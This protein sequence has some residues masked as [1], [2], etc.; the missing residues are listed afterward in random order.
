M[1]L[2]D[3]HIDP[4]VNRIRPIVLTGKRIPLP[5]TTAPVIS[6]QMAAFLNKLVFR[7]A[8]PNITYPA[9]RIIPDIS[10]PVTTA[11]LPDTNAP[12][13]CS[14]PGLTCAAAGQIRVS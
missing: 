4:P 13:V 8:I 12:S 14:N 2:T 3:N 6:S 11:E 1:V 9:P 10:S 7:A 5:K